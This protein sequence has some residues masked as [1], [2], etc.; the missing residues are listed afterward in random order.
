MY[1]SYMEAVDRRRVA[2]AADDRSQQSHI[3]RLDP[4][5]RDSGMSKPCH[6]HQYTMNTYSTSLSERM[7][8]ASECNCGA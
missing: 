8:P 7:R 1:L 6:N 2:G 5:I 4:L 3:Q